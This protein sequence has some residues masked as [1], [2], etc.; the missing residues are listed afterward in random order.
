[1]PLRDFHTHNFLCHHAAGRVVDYARA[2]QAAG[3]ASIGISDHNPMPGSF[4]D[5]RMGIGDLPEYFAMVEEAREA[6]AP[7]PVL[8]ALECDYLESGEAWIADLAGRA[9]WDYLIGSVHYIAPGWDVDNPK[10]LSR[11][12]PGKVE[13]VWDLYWAAVRRAVSSGQFDILGHADLAKKFGHR[14]DGDLRR[15]Y[16]P[17][18]ELLAKQDMAYELNTAGLRKPAG[19]MYPALGFLE[20]ACAAGVPVVLG[21]DAH[22]P[23]EVGADFAA[24]AEMLRRVGYRETATFSRRIRGSEPL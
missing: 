10:Y 6:V 7:L 8:I 21:S 11:F 16:E 19:E 4:D 23:G 9:D 22:A 3:L 15:Y 2:A 12:E 13:E 1:M 24:A 17:V 18:V 14:P 5:W 20:L